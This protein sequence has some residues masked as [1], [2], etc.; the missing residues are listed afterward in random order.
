MPVTDTPKDRYGAATP[1][2]D[3]QVLDGATG[4]AG[5]YLATELATTP[6]KRLRAA[7]IDAAVRCCRQAVE[8]LDADDPERA[9]RRLDRARHLLRQLR[10]TL[11]A[12]RD[13]GARR[14]FELHAHVDRMLTEAGH[15]ARRR[16]VLDTLDVLSSR[17]SVL[18]APSPGRR[19]PAAW[20]A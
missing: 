18:T 9:R 1:R 8:A 6:P 11:D 17:R 20:L 15:Y 14:A 3:R 13:E 16:T 2:R 7:L 4:P 12:P 19:R 5:A 10:D